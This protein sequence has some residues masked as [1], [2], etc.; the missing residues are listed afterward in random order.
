M[1]SFSLILTNLVYVYIHSAL[2]ITLKMYKCSVGGG[3][4]FERVLSDQSRLTELDAVLYTQQII[5][6]V[7]YL[8]KNFVLHLDLKVG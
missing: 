6:A 8:H 3:E 5:E 7:Q 1:I 4:L 2:Q